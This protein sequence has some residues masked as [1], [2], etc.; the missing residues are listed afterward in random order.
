MRSDHKIY[1]LV[2]KHDHVIRAGTKRDAH[3]L[4]LFIRIVHIFLINRRGE[5]MVSKRPPTARR[6]PNQMTSSA[7][8][9]VERG[10]PY[11]AAAARELHEEL[12]VIVSLKNKGRFDVMKRRTINY[13]FVG[14]APR[15][16]PDQVDAR[17][18]I[19]WRFASPAAIQRDI[20]DHPRR[21]TKPFHEALKLYLRSR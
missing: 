5:I 2:D 3:R 9:H 19:S 6:Y 11:Y 18:I 20:Q 4:K 14:K 12:G 10:E 13:L 1:D 7:G 8:G 15:I 17:E 16:V 21:Y